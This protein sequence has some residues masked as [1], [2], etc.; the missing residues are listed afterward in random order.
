MIVLFRLLH[1]LMRQLNFLLRVEAT[2]RQN[3]LFFILIINFIIRIITEVKILVDI[4]DETLISVAQVGADVPLGAKFT[5]PFLQDRIV[6]AVE[7]GA[8]DPAICKSA[9]K[10]HGPIRMGALR[11]VN[12]RELDPVKVHLPLFAKALAAAV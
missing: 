7:H 2:P 1:V 12:K 10:T 9:N 8:G 3:S 5:L 11:R 4:Q 6:L